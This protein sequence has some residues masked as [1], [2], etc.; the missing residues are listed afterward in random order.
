MPNRRRDCRRSRRAACEG[1]LFRRA[2]PA[3]AWRT[4]VQCMQPAVGLWH[5]LVRAQMNAPA[6]D[7][8]RVV[9]EAVLCGGRRA[10]RDAGIFA[11][12]APARDSRCVR[13]QAKRSPIRPGTLWIEQKVANLATAWKWLPNGWPFS[14]SGPLHQK[15][16]WFANRLPNRQLRVVLAFSRKTRPTAPA[17]CRTL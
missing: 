7:H 14:K 17:C 13:L 10:R 1:A 5:P 8:R 4:A 15:R 9:S 2:A 12:C 16:L 6:S 11:T 3:H